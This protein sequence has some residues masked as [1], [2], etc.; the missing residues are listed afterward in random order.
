MY[1]SH[2]GYVGIVEVLLKHPEVDVNEKSDVC[3][4]PKLLFLIFNT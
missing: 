4:I 3:S 1:A 2:S